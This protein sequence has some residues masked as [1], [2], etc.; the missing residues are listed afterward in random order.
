MEK[1]NLSRTHSI[2]RL[3][4]AVREPEFHR[5]ARGGGGAAGALRPQHAVPARFLRG[6]GQGGDPNKRYRAFY[7]EVGVTTSSFSQVDSRQA[8]GHMPT[9]GHFSTTITRPDLFESYLTE[10]LRLIMR[11]HG[12][13]VT[14]S[15]SRHADTGAFRLPGRHACRRLDGRPHQPADPRPVRRARPRRHRRPHRQRHVRDHAWRA[16]PAGALHRPAHRLFAAPAVALHGDQPAP[17]PEF[18]PVHQLPVLHRRVLRLCARP[19]GQ[20]RRRL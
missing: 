1:Q 10:Q 9:P 19:D 16:A 2:D 18:R 17:F 13:P 11:N 6:A 8:Y 5:R 20:W 7:P 14:V 15:E 12:V 4:R 3:A